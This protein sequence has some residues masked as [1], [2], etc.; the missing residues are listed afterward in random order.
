MEGPTAGD[1]PAVVAG[2]AAKKT[3]AG[4]GDVGISR[5]L[6]H[7]RI[8]LLPLLG[9]QFGDSAAD[10]VVVIVPWHDVP[11]AKNSR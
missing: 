4:L 5:E 11:V 1:G 6:R 10:F 3:H 2:L 8:F 9:K 7:G